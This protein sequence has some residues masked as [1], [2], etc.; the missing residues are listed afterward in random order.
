MIVVPPAEGC[1]V[2]ASCDVWVRA[3]PPYRLASTMPTVQRES[4]LEVLSVTSSSLLPR[5]LPPEGWLVKAIAFHPGGAATPALEVEVIGPDRARTTVEASSVAMTIRQRDLPLGAELADLELLASPLAAINLVVPLVATASL[6][7]AGWLL[8]KHHRRVTRCLWAVVAPVVRMS[9]VVRLLRGTAAD[10]VTHAY[11]RIV[12]AIRVAL[13]HRCDM[14]VSA[15]T[16]AELVALA[17]RCRLDP[18][19]R[20]VLEGLLHV[21][22]LVRFGGHLPESGEVLAD[23]RRARD[24]VRAPWFLRRR[25]RP[26]R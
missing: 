8:G 26:G 10:D 22:D 13:A 16:T 14:P 11:D 9:Q 12:A 17:R 1:W 21:S 18:V 5:L 6:M 7:G 3:V 4:G 20:S 23:L 15:L 2:A 24:L 19:E 25:R